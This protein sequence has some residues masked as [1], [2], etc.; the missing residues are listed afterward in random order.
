[1]ALQW[2]DFPSGQKGLYGVDEDYML[3][4]VYAQASQVALEVDPDPTQ[5]GTVIR[6]QGG[7]GYGA[8]RYCHLPYFLQY[9][10]DQGK[11]RF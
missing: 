8:L 5:T 3:N 11:T 2:A 10:E 4:G 1:M 7:T 6:A 9:L